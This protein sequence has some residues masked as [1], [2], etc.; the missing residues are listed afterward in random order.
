MSEPLRIFVV[1]DD[2]VILMQLEMMLEDADH[3]VVGTAMSAAEA[4]PRIRQAKPELVLLDL[5][6]KDGSSGID[7]AR[8]VRDQVDLTIV[9]VTANAR[10]L[11]DDME[12]AAAVI[13]KPFSEQTLQGSLAFLEECV[14]RP[15][16]ALDL[17]CGMR[18][19]TSYMARLDGMRAAM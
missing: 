16:P 6:L 4:V 8:A 9:F 5:Q 14:H 3:T 18:L 12:G 10:K 17:P 2:A 19:A 11:S 1:E 15:P 13:A 7:V